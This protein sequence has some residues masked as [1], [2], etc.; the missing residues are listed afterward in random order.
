MKAGKASGNAVMLDNG[1]YSTETYP[2]MKGRRYDWNKFR[3]L[4][5]PARDQHSCIGHSSL[6]VEDADQDR[7]CIFYRYRDL[8]LDRSLAGITGFRLLGLPLRVRVHHSGDPRSFALV[9]LMVDLVKTVRT[10]S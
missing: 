10:S 2:G 8:G 4:P 6:R 9:I 7:F 3:Q 1:R 5:H